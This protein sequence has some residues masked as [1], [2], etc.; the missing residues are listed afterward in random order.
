MTCISVVKGSCYSPWSVRNELSSSPGGAQAAPPAD[1]T[2]SPFPCLTFDQGLHDLL[3]QV[4]QCIQDWERAAH[5]RNAAHQRGRQQRQRIHRAMHSMDQGIL[6]E[7]HAAWHQQQGCGQS[8]RCK[9]GRVSAWVA[10]AAGVVRCWCCAS[11]GL[12]ASLGGLHLIDVVY[13][14]A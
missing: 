8:C 6:A 14:A 10:D 1:S 12:N 5:T 7:R 2:P 13:T 4:V 11:R 3:L 9:S